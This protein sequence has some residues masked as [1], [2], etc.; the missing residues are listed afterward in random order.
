MTQHSIVQCS[1]FSRLILIVFFLSA[2]LAPGW[3]VLAYPAAISPA[4][5]IR[6]QPDLFLDVEWYR[7]E[8]IRVA[9]LWNGGL[10]GNSGMGVY[11]DNFNGYFNV[12]LDRS[13]KALA[14]RGST[15]VAQSRAIYMNV[16]AYRVVGPEEGERFLNAVNLGVEFLLENFRDSEYGGYYWEVARTGRVLDD[17]KQGYGNVHPIFALAHAYSVT[18]D[19]A[20]LEAA[21]E[22]VEVVKEYFFDP[23]H[24]GAILPGFSRD[25]SEIIG[26]NNVDTFTHFFEALLIL[27]DVTEGEQR[28]EIV[29]LIV[30]EGNFLVDQL[31]RDQEGY[32]DRGY[33]AYNYDVEW[34]PTQVPYTRENQWTD[35]AQATPGHNI[36]LAYLLGRTVDRGFN[37]EWL[38]VADKLLKF[39]TEYVL[40]P[41]YGGMMYD[42]TDYEGQP[43]EGNPDNQY[44]VWWSLSE[45]A[46]TFLY[47]TLVRGQDYSVEFKQVEALINQHLTDPDFGGWYHYLDAENNLAPVALDKGNVWKVNY[48]RTML[49]VEVL[50]LAELYPDQ[51]AVLNAN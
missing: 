41:E 39:C 8:L 44:F 51:I 14:A 23:A 18:H 38:I 46:R 21:L 25:F 35:G 45:T 43:L 16:E 48:H 6:Q 31:Y 42:V 34:Q 4:S 13:W 20:H 15:S 12:T 24:P 7:E 3:S 11:R 40:H 27:Y 2:L 10:D 29:D 22:Q 47:Y 49:F 37:P 17:M 9:D 33:V 50:R 1:R 36:E 30:L 32:T 5:T 28:E 19:P 26:A